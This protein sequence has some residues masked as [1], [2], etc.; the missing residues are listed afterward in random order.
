VRFRHPLVRSVVYGSALPRQR[1]QVH[2]ALAEVTDPQEDPDPRAWHRAN[3]APG[4][5]EDV[6]AEL[7]RSA[8]RARARGG[9]A[10][11]AAFLERA[12][13]LTLDPT[14]RAERALAALRCSHRPGQLPS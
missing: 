10:A 13:T 3:A 12:A 9:V 2:G 4:P 6:A 14:R 1:Q 7:E 11:A 8:S 5:D